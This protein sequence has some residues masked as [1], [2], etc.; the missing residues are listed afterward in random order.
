[1]P[2]QAQANSASKREGE[3]REFEDLVKKERKVLW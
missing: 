1:M 2:V 3:M